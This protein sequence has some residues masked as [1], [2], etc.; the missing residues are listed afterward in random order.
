MN[1]LLH[2]QK[3]RTKT[4]K[5]FT[6]PIG[7][8]LDRHG[9]L[10]TTKLLLFGIL[11]SY[12]IDHPIPSLV[13]VVLISGSFGYSMWKDFLTRWTGTSTSIDAVSV[14]QESK[15]IVDRRA[16]RDHEASP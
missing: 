15:T 3:P 10:S 1:D 14:T 11:G 8:L 13:C 4:G 2:R 9:D 16:G 7:F 6:W 12:N 5:A